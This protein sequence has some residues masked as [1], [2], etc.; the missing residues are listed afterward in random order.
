MALEPPITA[1]DERLIA[2]ADDLALKF[3]ET[4]C[5]ELEP[6][7]MR[8]LALEADDE[9]FDALGALKALGAGEQ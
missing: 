4:A 8:L 9:S 2:E 6:E 1:P 3:Y 7:V 5:D